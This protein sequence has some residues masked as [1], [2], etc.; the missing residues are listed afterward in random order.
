M[1]RRKPPTHK[2]KKSKGAAKTKTYRAPD[3]LSK[4]TFK[5]ID[6]AAEILKDGIL[7]G[8]KQGAKGRQLLKKKAFS[9]VNTATRRLNKAIHEGSSTLRKGLKK[10]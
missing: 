10:L 8:A 7:A 9:L 2:K 5:L 1:T 6:E 3:A 4:A